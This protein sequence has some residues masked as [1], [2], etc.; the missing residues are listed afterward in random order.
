MESLKDILVLAITLILTGTV[1]LVSGKTLANVLAAHNNTLSILNNFLAGQEELFAELATARDI[2][3][4]APSNKAL[5][6]LEN[7]DA[8]M[9][10]MASEPGM[11]AAFLK[12]HVF[13][14]VWYTSNFTTAP[15]GGPSIV[16]TLMNDTAFTNVTGGQRVAG[17]PLPDNEGITFVS[18]NGN[19]AAVQKGD[20]NFTGGTIHIIDDVLTIPANIS[21]T[22]INA[23][24]TAAQG[25]FSRSGLVDS[26]NSESEITIFAPSNAGFN[27]VGAVVSGLDA[28]ELASLMG[29]HVLKGKVLYTAMMGNQTETT[30]E[31]NEIHIRMEAGKIFVN[32]AMIVKSNLFANNG[33]VHIC[34]NVL[35]PSNENASPDP[36]AAT[37]QPAFSGASPTNSVPFTYGVPTPT[38]TSSAVVTATVTAVGGGGYGG[39]APATAAAPGRTTCTMFS[40]LGLLVSLTLA[41]QLVGSSLF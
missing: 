5:N 16:T 1:P 23:N 35:N 31:G 20:Y 32:S 10:A 2:T 11:V 9:N 4:L 19:K 34:D 30:S 8:V 39:G 28:A 12:Y 24:L 7:N 33:V 15:S 36:A 26:I 40:S 17:L 22:L 29:Y 21:D 6:K 37:Q 38:P 18:G 25:A 14:G 13:Q 3:V 41:V 27:A